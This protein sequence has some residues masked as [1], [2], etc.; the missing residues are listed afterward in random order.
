MNE[1][2]IVR[3]AILNEVEGGAFYEM[4]AA[5][6]TNTEVKAALDYL[7]KEEKEHEHW[8]RSLNGNLQEI[9]AFVFDWDK[10]MELPEVKSP[11]IFDKAGEVFQF[12]AMELAIFGAGLLMEKNSVDFY[13]KAA[14]D[15]VTPE[16]KKLY[17][18]LVKW[19]TVHM[20]KLEQIYEMMKNEWWEKQR[21]SPA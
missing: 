10:M 5:Q 18:Q 19:E 21:F 2:N 11:G 16:A 7:G 3:Q 8:L 12:N 9:N 17:E 20:E 14:E 4:A 1:L 6:A 13:Q 15:A